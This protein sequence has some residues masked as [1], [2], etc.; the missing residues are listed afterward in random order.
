MPASVVS[1]NILK[2]P[3]QR[4]NDSK[5]KTSHRWWAGSTS[6][7]SPLLSVITNY[8]E[9]MWSDNQINFSPEINHKLN[10]GSPH[11]D[12]NRDKNVG[13]D[14]SY[15]IQILKYQAGLEDNIVKI[16]RKERKC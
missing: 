12:Y 16:Y 11:V 14:H 15:K 3:K 2:K 7:E 5:W 1:S 8:N 4:C 13:G 6:E 9:E 10:Y